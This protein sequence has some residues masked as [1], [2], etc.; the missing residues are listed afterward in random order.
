MVAAP[1]PTP[2][3]PL[4]PGPP[5]VLGVLVVHDGMSWLPGVL[6]SLAVQD[7]PRFDLV[8]VDTGSTDGS[9]ELLERRIPPE[10]LLRLRDSAGVGDALAA[11]AR[12]V[13][14]PPDTLLIVHDDL[15]LA[16]DAVGRLARD[17]ADDPTLAAVGPK[18]REW[19][20]RPTLQQV[21]RTIDRF[22]RVDLGLERDEL[23]Q[24]QYDEE[25]DVLAVST[26]GML[27]RSDALDAVGGFDPRMRAMGDDIDLC[28]RLWLAGWRIAVQ[29]AA[30]GYHAA[31]GTRGARPLWDGGA[32]TPRELTERHAL[33]SLLRNHGAARLAWS[34]PV[35]ALLAAAKTLA[36]LATRRVG[37]AGATVRAWLW[38]AVQLPRTLRLRWVTQ[39]DRERSEDEIAPLLA[40]GEP[41]WQQWADTTRAWLAGSD[42]PALL[43]GT[44]DERAVPAGG[45]I[46]RL[47]RRGAAVWAG[48][49]LLVLYL[50]GAASL[51]GSG[52]LLGGEI[53]PWPDAAGEFVAA[54]ASPF[55]G[56]PAGT[57]G[58]PSPIQA[59]LGVASLGLGGSPWLAQTVLVLGLLPFA[60]VTAL[61]AG[62]LITERSGPR[63]LAATLYACSP[64][65]AGA[66]AQARWGALVVAAL[67]PAL[68]LLAFR[69][70]NPDTA[71][72]TAWRA[73]ALFVFASVVAIGAAPPA[74]VL[75]A[76][77]LLL[78][79]IVATRRDVPRHGRP[80]LR[81][82][83]STVAPLLLLSPW[84]ASLIAGSARL[85]AQP[86]V[87]LP[88]WRAIGLAPVVLPGLEST[89]GAMLAVVLTAALIG[90]GLLLGLPLRP[91][92]VTLLVTTLIVSATAAWV[93]A[94][95][96]PVSVWS[97]LMLLPG[98]LAVGGLAAV[99]GRTFVPALSVHAFGLRQV[100][101]IAGVLVVG[102]G[103]L[104]GLARIASDPWVGVER[105]ED[106]LPPVA[107]ASEELPHRLLLLDLDDDG[108]RWE[109]TGQDGPSMR[110]VGET[111]SPAIAAAVG[112]AV[113]GMATG[114]DLGAAS[115]LA[116]AG[117]REV[118]L[119]E[120]AADSE[121]R[122]LLIRQPELEPI[123]TGGG[124]VL[125][126][127]A[128][129]PRASVLP[130]RFADHL[131]AG[132]RVDASDVE[133][134]ALSGG[135]DHWAGEAGPG[136]LLLTE[137]ASAWAATLDGAPLDPVAV[138]PTV[139][140]LPPVAAYEV[141]DEGS[142]ELQ[143]GS[144][145]RHRTLVAGQ[146]LLALVLGSLLL[147][148]PRLATAA[149]AGRR[150]APPVH[151]LPGLDGLDGVRAATP[152]A[153][154][155]GPS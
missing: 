13:E 4:G 82:A 129:V 58:F 73:T 80:R 78:A 41:R 70:G 153:R 32:R 40:S 124:R 146:A 62:R 131:L 108:V 102:I 67:F 1:T 147:R 14:A 99:A 106:V 20:E 63:V 57:V 119:T 138:E 45:R 29:P 103:L 26:A 151:A 72:P 145:W 25:R 44:I 142:V 127:A 93:A 18:L 69:L 33:A 10:R 59:V 120:D 148:P 130:D 84:L 71:L 15:A 65:V 27:V 111:E 31:A 5:G 12:V 121:L 136:T 11:A 154:A 134:V 17:L 137:D 95:V 155:G 6:A 35:A 91:L 113:E 61:R 53:R 143:V 19:R 34:L 30:V 115:R 75:V 39:R 140:E 50:V 87:P 123:P 49:P 46:G 125:Q 105:V 128:W 28:W 116:L 37:A 149:R 152:S 90:L 107:G 133:P 3:T 135:S 112:R 109:L 38:N 81:V 52:V 21:G 88:A 92:P 66:L 144:P 79:V 9:W 101:A 118:V 114:S 42:T 110:G 139:E 97:P 60:W 117:V 85:P 23:D 74:G 55:G 122:E 89:A 100:S 83:V 86:E 150:D 132:R 68:V 104:G 56:E 126:V 43:A 64:P 24:G 36:L 96:V 94:R 16:P 22:G 141:P 48:I 77:A 7:H 8:A 47:L 76:S 98:A 54:Y 51:L 2:F